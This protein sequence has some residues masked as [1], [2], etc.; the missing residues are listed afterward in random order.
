MTPRAASSVSAA[1]TRP[2]SADRTDAWR[3]QL[4]GPEVATIEHVHEA[5]MA[6]FQ[7]APVGGPLSPW[8]W[9]KLAVKA[10]Y[11]QYHRWRNRRVPQWALTALERAGEV[12]D[13]SLVDPFTVHPR[14]TVREAAGD[15]LDGLDATATAGGGDTTERQ[16]WRYV[17][18]DGAMLDAVGDG[19]RVDGRLAIAARR[20]TVRRRVV[21]RFTGGFTG[22]FVVDSVRR[23]VVLWIDHVAFLR[24]RCPT[25]HLN[26]PFSRSVPDG[27]SMSSRTRRGP[28][29]HA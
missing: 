12:S 9:S 22:G 27:R 25:T 4:S 24:G 18:G 23:S 15:T 14:P 5:F 16:A 29:E 8:R 13:R 26:P 20:R 10:A 6:K 17:S 2:I 21:G 28:Q 7:Y 1:A 11:W 19:D 3:R